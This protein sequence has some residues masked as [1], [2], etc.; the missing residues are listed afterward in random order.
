L[1]LTNLHTNDGLSTDANHVYA[2]GLGANTR[3]KNC[4]ENEEEMSPNGASE[5]LDPNFGLE[6]SP[7]ADTNWPQIRCSVRWNQPQVKHSANLPTGD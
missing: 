4:E 5:A 2:G 1:A 7:L 3:K 6:T